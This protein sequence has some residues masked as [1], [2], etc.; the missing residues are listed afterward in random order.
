M[1]IISQL[2]PSAAAE[3]REQLLR[4]GFSAETIRQDE[5]LIDGLK[6]PLVAFSHRP[7]DTRTSCA[8]AISADGDAP[9][10]VAALRTIGAPLVYVHDKGYWDMWYQGAEAPELFWP[11]HRGSLAK[12]IREHRSQID[13]RSIFRA[14]TIWRAQKPEQMT[15]VDVGFLNLVESE[16]GEELCRLVERMLHSTR[17]GLHWSGHISEAD[18]QWLVKANFWLLAA[19]ILHDKKVS[20]FKSLDLGDVDD[21][22]RRVTR[23]Y[24]VPIDEETPLKRRR[25]LTGAVHDL[26]QFASLELIST[27]AL[28]HVYENAL[29]TKETRRSLGTHSTPGW[30]VEYM[31]ARLTPWI[32]EMPGDRRSVYEPATGHGPFLL[33]AMRLLSGL[34][35][36]SGMNDAERHNYLKQ[37][38]RGAEI[39]NFA[40]EVARLSL[41]LADIPNHNGWH[42]DDSDIFVG[43][44]LERRAAAADII[45]SNPPFEKGGVKVN[46]DS[47]AYISKAAELVRRT[48]QAA[49]PGTCFGFI[50]PQTM[51]D[52]KK[53]STLRKRLAHECEWLE[54]CSLPDKVFAKA[55]A[56]TAVLIGRKCKIANKG[57]HSILC[58]SVWDKGLPSFA[59]IGTAT[60]EQTVIQEEFAPAPTFSFFVPHLSR[61][62]RA[63]EQYR[64][65]GH[66]A[67]V[68][69]GFIFRSEKDPL[70]PKGQTQISNNR[71]EGYELGFYDLPGAP[72]T[73]L[74]PRRV[75]INTNPLAIDRTV[76][77]WEVGHPQIVMNH[78]RVQR[79]PWRLK[80]YCDL[81]GHRTRGE[82]L[83]VRSIKK[84]LSVPVLW[85]IL[86]SPLAN[87]YAHAHSTKKHILSGLMEEMP[88]PAQDDGWA[89]LELLVDAY[90]KAAN[91]WSLR[92]RGRKRI[93]KT[94]TDYSAERQQQSE[95]PGLAELGIK[96]LEQGAETE[97]LKLLHWRID[98]EVLRLYNLDPKHER[99]LLDY[100]NGERRVGVP[101]A[102]THYFPPGFSGANTLREFLA[103]TADWPKLEAEHERLVEKEY[104]G[105]I[106]KDEALRLDELQKLADLQ[107]DLVAP[108]PVT[109]AEA[110]LQRLKRAGLLAE[111]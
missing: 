110:E 76:A 19:R 73:Y 45:L 55:G 43:N 69:Q 93:G 28:A 26:Q 40:R 11:R 98:A 80:A 111:H 81:R 71:R 5:I 58:R 13:P 96:G 4:V 77:G 94:E 54:V 20:N 23:H 99:L 3:L 101:F 8:A 6:I 63:L 39:D 68:G 24:G 67:T 27:E 33:G 70:F 56:E 48:T 21:V 65:L 100:F 90:F 72:D 12:F 22:F 82:F 41:T 42:L 97:K 103:I 62:W 1:A 49:R 61:I 60:V 37:R 75:W 109:E 25:A 34:P 29:V 32:E 51:L 10:R 102:Q 88:F 108:W 64:R 78:I 106:M 52:T 30:L 50:L 59:A 36:C 7:F 74:L 91:A 107:S 31:L 79:G 86:N 57:A 66:V 35:Y 95:L 104:R 15:F 16:A 44:Q 2:P 105:K 9:Q 85:A 89:S 17:E 87:A 18:A 47:V 84:H 14:K 46:G 38:L 83:I 53:L 92:Q